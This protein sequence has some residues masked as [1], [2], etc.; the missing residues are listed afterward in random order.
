MAEGHPLA[1]FPVVIEIPVAWGELDAFGHVNNTV[2]FRYFE[3]ARI[4]C[5]EVL[6]YLELM[7]TTGVGPILASTDCRFRIPLTY[8][9]R[10]RVGA[11][12]TDVGADEFTMGYAV[13]SERH[14]RLAAEGGGRIVSFDY[15]Q[16][17]KAPLQPELLERLM[18][19]GS[20]S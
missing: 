9:D 5:F 19:F 10:L 16:R 11:R 14:G 8:P 13:H 12:I 2:Y 15:G 7:R 17:R 4:A 1:D 20:R 6:D 3:S 18:R